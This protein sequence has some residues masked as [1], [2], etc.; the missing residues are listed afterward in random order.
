MKNVFKTISLALALIG[1]SLTGRAQVSLGL[2]GLVS[3]GGT[4]IDEIGPGFT[5]VIQGEN[6]LGFEVGPYLKLKLGPLYLRP[7]AMYDYRFGDVDYTDNN[8]NARVNSFSVHKIQV[9]ITLGLHILGP[10]GI[11]AAPVYNYILAATDRYDEF[12]VDLGKN[13][14]GYRAG[15]I[16]DFNSLF[17]NVS[18]QGVTYYDSDNSNARFKEPYKIVF[19]LGF[20]LAGGGGGGGND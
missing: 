16:A 5:D 8:G 19:G 17:V 10:L 7:A 11:E 18:L 6:I 20:R 13:G 14:F 9:P 2:Q 4:R 15:I 3:T 1:L 12:E